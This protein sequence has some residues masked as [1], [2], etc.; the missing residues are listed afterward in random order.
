MIE[1][2][3]FGRIVINGRTYTN[4]VMIFSDR[5]TP[6]RRKGGHVVSIE[7]L[8]AILREKPKVIV[9][10]TGASGLVRIAPET[11]REL[12]AQ[13]IELVAAPTRRAIEIFNDRFMTENVIGGFHLTC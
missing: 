10:G 6:W 3:K 4:D 8:N 11:A 13:G 9:I 1:A 5:V 12:A 7:D 2:Y